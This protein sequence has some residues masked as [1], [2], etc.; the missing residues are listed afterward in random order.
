MKKILNEWKKFLQEGDARTI[1]MELETSSDS[2]ILYHAGWMHPSDAF[3]SGADFAFTGEPEIFRGMERPMGNNAIYFSTNKSTASGYKR[4]SE[5]SY[6]YKVRFPI[7][8]IAG[9]NPN[10][11]TG[12]ISR[13]EITLPE[14][15]AEYFF[16][17]AANNLNT[18]YKAKFQV[19]NTGLEVGV[20]DTSLIEV[21][22]WSRL[23]TDEDVRKW[24]D[25]NIE[26]IFRDYMKAK[27]LP[28][29]SYE[30]PDATLSGAMEIL[31]KNEMIEFLEGDFEDT[32]ISTTH[33]PL[34]KKAALEEFKRVFPTEYES[35]TKSLLK[36]LE[37]VKQGK[38]HA[39][40]FK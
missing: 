3:R 18:D 17:T 24:F 4:F 8:K 25:K 33:L 19:V 13:N 9:G 1:E 21:L 6:L 28:D 31:S 32:F 11:P 2:I 22:K 10:D 5:L 35:Y 39:N 7:S 30:I 23:F 12:I 36:V 38:Q 37:T 34:K 27:R 16:Q 15:Q 40:I 26:P 20:Y 14:E 29:G